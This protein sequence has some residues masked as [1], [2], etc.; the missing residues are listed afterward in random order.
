MR[1][2]QDS[3]FDGRHIGSDDDTGTEMLNLRKV[4][5]AFDLPYEHILKYEEI[6]EKLKLIMAKDGPLFVEVICD[7]NQ[8][9]VEPIKPRGSKEEPDEYR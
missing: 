3:Y 9:I 1:N 2:W 6:D 7:S 4:A 5:N 8:K